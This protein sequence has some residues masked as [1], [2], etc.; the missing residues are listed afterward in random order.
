MTTSYMY[1]SKPKPGLDVLDVQDL[2]MESIQRNEANGITGV[3]YFGGDF[4]LQI[5]EGE[6]VPTHNLF[7]KIK[8]DTRHTNVKVINRVDLAS[9]LFRAH[10]MKF[11]DGSRS[12]ML[13]RKFVYSRLMAAQPADLDPLAFSLLK[14]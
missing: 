2:W 11:V 5:I 4:L 7:R 8:A 10:A 14:V 13:R 6:D 12:T 1:V 9:N 3:L